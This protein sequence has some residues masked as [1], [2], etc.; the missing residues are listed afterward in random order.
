[1]LLELALLLLLLSF[2]SSSSGSSSSSAS[3]LVL[4]CFF[5]LLPLEAV[6]ALVVVATDDLFFGLLPPAANELADGELEAELLVDLGVEAEAFSSLALVLRA[7]PFRDK[8]NCLRLPGA[9]RASPNPRALGF[10]SGRMMYHLLL[11][12]AAVRPP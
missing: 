9:D 8:A 5:L 6:L 10:S 12:E 11:I 3:G 1:M 2:S 7:P 4:V